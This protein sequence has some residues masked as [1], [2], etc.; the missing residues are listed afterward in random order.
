MAN[1]GWVTIGFKGDTKQLEKDIKDSERLLQQYD[2]KAEK[3]TQ[4]KMKIEAEINIKEADLQRKIKAIQQKME[5]DVKAVTGGTPYARGAREDKIRESAQLKINQLTEQYEQYLKDADDKVKDIDR[6]LE[7]TTSE[8]GKLN[9]KVTEL[10]QKQDGI[11]NSNSQM[12]MQMTSIGN[13]IENVIKKVARWGLAIFGIRSAYMFVRQAMSS[14]SGYNEQIGTDVEYIRFALATALQPVIEGIIKLVYKLLV[15]TA[16][17]IKAWFGVNIFAKA[18]AKAF[19]DTNKAVKNT[20]KSAKELQKTLAGFDEMNILQQNGDSTLGGGGGGVGIKAPSVDLSDW[21]NV[22][23]PGWIKWIAENKDKVLSFFADIIALIATVKIAAF[24]MDLL[25]ISKV[26]DAMSGLALFGMLAGIAITVM[27]IY[28]TIRGLIDWIADPTWENF[29]KILDGLETVLI[30]VGIA[31]VALNASNPLGWIAIGIGAIGKFI[32]ALS[33]NESH[34]LTTKEATKQLKEAQEELTKA[35]DS[36]VSAVDRAENAEQA[37]KDAE[38]KHGISGKELFNMVKHGT[39]DYKNM[40]DAQREVYKAYLEN[41][42]AKKNLK[43]TTKD[44]E[45]ATHDE[46]LASLEKKRALAEESGNYDKLKKS[47]IEAVKEE[48]ISMSEAREMIL[49]AMTQMDE[50]TQ[51]TFVKDMPASILKAFDKGEY[52]GK[53][54]AFEKFWNGFI[55][56]LDKNIDVNVTATYTTKGSSKKKNA[57]GAMFYPSMLPKL[58]VGGIINMPGSGVPYH[59]SIIGE[60]GAEAV[61]P[62]TDSQQ[63]ALLGEAIGKYITVNATMINQMNGRVISRELQRVQNDSDFAYNR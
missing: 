18:T 35:T 61:V 26:L 33:D 24:L 7:K 42:S 63:M 14:L 48:K 17:I 43:K 11:I 52:E 44:L 36:Y 51:Q 20:N 9:A 30:G 3:L 56:D 49:K 39:L 41:E 37:L 50:K 25:N 19:Q 16:Y 5:I 13:G 46:T 58:A 45:K 59:G 47:I 10:K 31:M 23:I 28:Q 57:K 22:E 6:D 2:K 40:N 34:L 8:Q 60:R 55:A 21:E 62:L 29:K 1:N 27:G 32:G 38:E 4:Q 54:F 53:M 15:Y 12:P